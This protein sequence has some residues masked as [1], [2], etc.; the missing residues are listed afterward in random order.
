MV[1]LQPD[2]LAKLDAWI[3]ENDA[4]LTRPAAIRAIL[5]KTTDDV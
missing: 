2:Q 5:K 4:T 3:K 1:R